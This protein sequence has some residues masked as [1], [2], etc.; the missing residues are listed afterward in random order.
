MQFSFSITEDKQ[1]NAGD[2]IS[3][4]NESLSRV[5]IESSRRAEQTE[6]LKHRCIALFSR[7]EGLN[8]TDSTIS[9]Y[10]HCACTAG[11]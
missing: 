2:S 3:I 4:K 5:Y 8:L 6:E 1:G 10:V 11:N 9:R 7:S